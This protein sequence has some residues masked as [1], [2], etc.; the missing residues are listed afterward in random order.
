MAF[1][2]DFLS[3][4]KF[5]GCLPE[6]EEIVYGGEEVCTAERIDALIYSR[7]GLK[8]I[9]RYVIQFAV[10]N[11]ESKRSIIF[12]TNSIVD[13][14]DDCAGSMKPEASYLLISDCW[15]SL[16]F[17]TARYGADLNDPVPGKIYMGC[18]VTSITPS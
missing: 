7:N 10:I 9:N 5:D 14:H 6:T 13:V 4:L 3:V 17:G 16:I 18:D 15:S 8:I 12:V 2:R 11:T 1:E